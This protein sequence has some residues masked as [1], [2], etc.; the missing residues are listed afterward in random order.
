[1]EFTE[2]LRECLNGEGSKVLDS[3]AF[4]AELRELRERAGLVDG[5]QKE[6]WRLRVELDDAMGKLDKSNAKT[7]VTKENREEGATYRSSGMQTVPEIAKEPNGE[8]NS[9]LERLIQKHDVLARNYKELVFAREKLEDKLRSSK[10]LN[11]DWVEYANALEKQIGKLEGKLASHGISLNGRS[12]GSST[13]K[14]LPNVPAGSNGMMSVGAPDTSLETLSRE[15]P[16]FLCMS[17]RISELARNATDGLAGNLP[18]QPG[19]LIST[20]HLEL[21][22]N[23]PARSDPLSSLARHKPLL[24]LSTN[25]LKEQGSIASPKPPT[26]RATLE[27]HDLLGSLNSHHSSTTEEDHDAS[28]SISNREQV[29]IPPPSIKGESSPDIPIVISSRSIKKRGDRID[30]GLNGHF[31]YTEVKVEVITS[32]PVGL[33]GIQTLFPQ[34]S[35]DLDEMGEKM[36]TPKKRR[37]VM[38]YSHS[39]ISRTIDGQAGDQGLD[40]E[41]SAGLIRAVGQQQGERSAQP[42]GRPSALQAGSP[43]KQIL[44][45]TSGNQRKPKRRRLEDS[46]RGA[47]IL[48]EDGE[49]DVALKMVSETVALTG[50]RGKRAPAD[51]AELERRLSGLLEEPT[52][53][54]ADLTPARPLNFSTTTAGLRARATPLLKTKEAAGSIRRQMGAVTTPNLLAVPVNTPNIGC[55]PTTGKKRTSRTSEDIGTFE[56]D[57]PDQEPLRARP[58]HRLGLEHFKINPRYNQGSDY[59]YSDVVR[60]RESRR[61]LPGCTRP[62]CCGDKFRKFIEFVRTQEQRTLSQIEE[63]ERLLEEHLGDNRGRLRNMTKREKEELLVQAKTTELANKASKHRHA[64]ERRRSP[65]GFW[66]S[67]FPST[68]ELLVDR[69]QAA[70]VQRDLV[71]QR[72]D[73]AMRPGGK[74]LFRDE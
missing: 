17:E 5:L 44:P 55:R 16:N 61:C 65:P 50:N 18:P 1:M 11:Y 30:T 71:Q 40:Q 4:A 72:Y 12:T 35:L 38:Q 27:A 49:N 10:K 33:A 32:S 56:A 67:D 62:E 19:Q 58:V 14:V 8:R 13:V 25:V 51:A 9:R 36:N 70:R 34:E 57:D 20:N 47:V 60:G 3:G 28:P 73:E 41:A 64:Y 21:Q 26:D 66:R 68:Q 46:V 37:Q 69:Q 39:H 63:D 45:R 52:P 74:W 42:K 43:N 29:D 48:A 22:P 59:A 6:N 31:P 54:K 15:L 2:L 7:A 53:E 24:Q 23:I